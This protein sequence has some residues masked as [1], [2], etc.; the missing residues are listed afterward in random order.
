MPFDGLVQKP[1]IEFED[2]PALLRDRK[3]WP[4]GFKWD[5]RRTD[6][7][8]IGLV[9]ALGDDRFI[10][11]LYLSGYSR[12]VIMEIFVDMGWFVPFF[13]PSPERVARRLEKVLRR[14]K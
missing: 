1:V 8:A 3:R 14:G 10:D 2:L 12:S 11:R 5:F 13:Y 9:Y 6:K 7:C 4:V